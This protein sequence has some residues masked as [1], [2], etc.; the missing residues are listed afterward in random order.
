MGARGK[1]CMQQLHSAVRGHRR[2]AVYITGPRSHCSG[3]T[4]YSACN[5]GM[6]PPVRK[7]RLEDNRI[8]QCSGGIG[9]FRDASSIGEIKHEVESIKTLASIRELGAEG[10]AD[11]QQ[12]GYM[13]LELPGWLVDCLKTSAVARYI[14]KDAGGYSGMAELN[15]K[16]LFARPEPFDNTKRFDETAGALAAVARLVATALLSNRQSDVLTPSAIGVLRPVDGTYR[17]AS[18]AHIN[19]Y[20]QGEDV[21]DSSGQPSAYSPHT[22]GGLLTLVTCPV[23]DRALVVQL[24]GGGEEHVPLEPGIAAVLPGEALGKVSLGAHLCL[25]VHQLLSYSR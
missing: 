19:I 22:D 12:Y 20:S 1:R 2:Q 7:L 14:D 23:S 24:P 11:L 13:L 9:A 21:G 10:A 18:V 6:P 5:F 3:A 4:Q 25:P 8:L 16:R 15:G 17:H